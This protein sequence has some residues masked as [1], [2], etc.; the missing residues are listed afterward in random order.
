MSESA[1]VVEATPQGRIAGTVVVDLS[2]IARVNRTMSGCR[3]RMLH[4]VEN[5]L[6]ESEPGAGDGI[7]TEAHLEHFK[8]RLKSITGDAWDDIRKVVNELEA[9]P[10]PMDRLIEMQAQVATLNAHV[11]EGGAGTLLGRVDQLERR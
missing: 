8:R 4:F 1:M 10:S 6:G 3:G 2:G 9:V 11:I 7:L 5:E